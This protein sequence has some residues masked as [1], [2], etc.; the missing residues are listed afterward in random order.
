MNC[1][2]RAAAV[3]AA[4]V[5]PAAMAAP[6]AATSGLTVAQVL[7]R[8]PAKDWRPLDPQ[9]TLLMDLAGDGSRQVII[10]LAPRF[11]PRHAANIRTLAHEGYWDGLAIMRVQDNYVTQWGDP[12]GEVPEKTK[13]LGSASPKLPAEF[14]VPLK[15]L[16]LVRLP[17]ADGWAPVTGF[18]DGMPVAADPKT[19]Q[20]WLAHCY[21]IVGAGRDMAKDSSNGTELYTVIGQSPRGLDLNITV[22]GRVLQGMQHLVALPRGTAEM[23]FYGP[24]EQR[25]P[26]QRV[27]LLADVPE[28][29][30]PAL[31]VLRTDSATWP[32]LL[33]A[34]RVRKED[35][36]VHSPH[37]IGLCNATVPTRPKVV[38][39]SPAK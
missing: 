28:A 21:G 13:P 17:D 32:A 5:A 8:S 19:G 12:N 25:T 39:E 35:W 38:V 20:A 33:Q 34:R 26:I 2:F 14:S 22:V 29:E 27:R 6:A 23:G 24:G 7:E 37:H 36:F 10:E 31:E 1:L 30:R 9:N 18:V 11:A 3:V 16:P 15:G 4:F